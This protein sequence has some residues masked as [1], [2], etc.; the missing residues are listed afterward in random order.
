MGYFNI[1]VTNKMVK[2]IKESLPEGYGVELIK[3]TPEQYKWHVHYEGIYHA[4]DY[5]DYD[6]NKDICKVIKINYPSDYYAMPNYITTKELREV[7]HSIRGDKNIDNYKT[8]LF[9][10]LEV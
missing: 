4:M 1:K 9:N 8:E 3:L 7:Y 2:I 5:G 6:S 10:Y